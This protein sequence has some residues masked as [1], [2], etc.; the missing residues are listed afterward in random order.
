M[1]DVKYSIS[2]PYY[3]TTLDGKFLDLMVNRKITKKD[4]DKLYQIDRSYHLRP[5]LMAFDL[6]K[7]AKLWWVFAARNPDVLKDPLFGFSTGTMIYIPTKATLA[8]DL[9][10]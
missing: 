7:D 5:D 1:A 8:L 6:Y 3:K 4:N 9:G 10:L 2:S